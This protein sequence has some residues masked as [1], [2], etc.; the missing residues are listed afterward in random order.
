MLNSLEADVTKSNLSLRV[1]PSGVD[2]TGA[3]NIEKARG[4]E[5]G[6]KRKDG[7]KVKRP[8][9]YL[10]RIEIKRLTKDIR[11]R[12]SRIIDKLF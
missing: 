2:S 1:I 11:V 10:S 6:I 3:S 4:H 8:F 7:S 9:L 5:E 12:V